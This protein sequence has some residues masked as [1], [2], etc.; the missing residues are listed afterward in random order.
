MYDSNYRPRLWDS[1][2]DARAA[3]DRMWAM[4]DVA[5]PS[6]D[7][8]LVLSPHNDAAQI[9]AHLA[10]LCPGVAV[11]NRGSEGP[12]YLDNGHWQA[13]AASQTVSVVDSTAAGDSFNAGFSA[14]HLEAATI[15]A[16]CQAGHD[17]ASRVIQHKGAIM[18]DA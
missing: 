11:L 16:A 17:L 1:P 12:R 10:A 14:A 8:E 15:K 3:N 4:F 18:P 13:L 6:L 5:L 2:S 7:D 9:E